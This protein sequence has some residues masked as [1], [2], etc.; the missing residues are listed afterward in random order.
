MSQT[1]I[2]AA[3]DQQYAQALAD[4]KHG[5]TAYNRGCRCGSCR[6]AKAES[7]QRYR[8]QHAE[9]PGGHGYVSYTHGCRCEICRV[10]KAEYQRELREKRH[11][12]RR[13][14][15]R[16]SRA[17]GR[18]YVDGITHGIG[19]YQNHSCRCEVCRLAASAAYRR[20]RH[21]R[22]TTPTG[23]SHR[24]SRQVDGPGARF[25]RAPG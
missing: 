3:A 21:A 18:N 19:G 14:V 23:D 24:V 10:A 16:P 12:V 5:I 7:M 6:S 4:M 2:L 11:R 20:Q 13:L 22:S 8:Q 25:P 17:A 9:D 1:A 15:E